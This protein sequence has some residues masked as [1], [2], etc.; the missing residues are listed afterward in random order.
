VTCPHPPSL[1]VTTG[2]ATWCPLCGTDPGDHAGQ[3]YTVTL[4]AAELGVER[5]VALGAIERLARGGLVER[6]GSV[7]EDL[8]G[9]R[10][11]GVWRVAA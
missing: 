4:L 9:L 3:S 11:V 1:H 10:A 5:R 7:A 2:D 8:R 6:V